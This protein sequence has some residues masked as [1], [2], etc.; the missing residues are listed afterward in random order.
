M[1]KLS[2]MLLLG[3]VVLYTDTALAQSLGQ[4]LP[5]A[6]TRKALQELPQIGFDNWTRNAMTPREWVVI[7]KETPTAAE[8]DPESVP[9]VVPNSMIIQFESDV[10][11]AEIQDYLEE[12]K[13]QVIQAF[14]SIGAVQV[15]ADISRFFTP[16]L[17][18][19]SPNDVLLR[20]MVQAAE[21]FKADERVQSATPDFVLTDKK[22][23]AEEQTYTNM[24]HPTEIITS[25]GAD[26]PA[27][28]VD[29]GIAD[30]EADQIW[31]EPGAHDGVILGVMD[32]GFA[33][34]EDITYLRFPSAGPGDNHGNHVAAIACAKHNGHGIRGVLPNCFVVARS[35][36]VFFQSGQGNPQVRFM[37]LFSQILGTLSQFIEEEEQIKTYN[38]SLGYNWRRNFGINP[39]LPESLQ[40]RQLVEMQGALLVSVLSVAQTRDKVIFSA[41][42]NDSSGLATPIN[43]KYASPFNWAAI[44][45]RETG[46][47][48]NG[49]IVG[50]HDPQ[51]ARAPFSNSGADISCP[52]TNILSAVAFDA[53]NAPSQSAYGK[54][55]GTSMASP[56]C[57]AAHVLFRLVRPNYTGVEAANC[58]MRAGEVG[59]DGIPR[60]KLARSLAACPNR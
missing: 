48:N 24:V 28:I 14:P 4:Q 17:S 1:R 40:W 44:T 21:A 30:I 57:A 2:S 31:S 51:G 5:T 22:M 52:G 11:A 56:H 42:G 49:F 47:A 9:F 46:R 50:A 37:T 8:E 18:D 45:A 58:M 15:D 59:A 33:R 26:D 3:I 54:M 23:D 60:L 36:D 38:V 7:E 16:E 19:T 6:E 34:H 27:E 20:G 43:A 39:D 10:S 29:W 32:A 53:Q 13:L 55:S 12:N 25:F 41:A 35:A